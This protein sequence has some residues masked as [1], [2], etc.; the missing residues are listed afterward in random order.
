M[1]EIEIKHLLCI[2][3]IK[4]IIPTNYPSFNYN[5]YNFDTGSLVISPAT[6]RIQLSKISTT[7][8]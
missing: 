7:Q 6:H 5:S 8:M 1:S 3:N 2:T 4:I